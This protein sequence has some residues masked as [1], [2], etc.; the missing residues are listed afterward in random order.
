MTKEERIEKLENRVEQLEED[1][2]LIKLKLTS[3]ISENHQLKVER[4]KQ[5]QRQREEKEAQLE[6][7]YEERMGE[8]L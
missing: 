2:F 1:I 3:S 4:R 7:E 5:L 6:R 8:D